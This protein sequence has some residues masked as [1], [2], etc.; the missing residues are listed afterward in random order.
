[1]TAIPILGHLLAIYYYTMGDKERGNYAIMLT[2]RTTLVVLS[3]FVTFD[4]ITTILGSKPPKYATGIAAAVI[5]VMYDAII[6]LVFKPFGILEAFENV[7]DAGVWS[8][9]IFNL[10]LDFYIGYI[11]PLSLNAYGKSCGNKRKP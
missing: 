8:D 7:K 9:S 3:P 10:C 5:G 11:I 1:M 6:M 4:L 2:T